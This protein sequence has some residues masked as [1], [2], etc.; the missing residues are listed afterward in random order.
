MTLLGVV[1]GARLLALE[2]AVFWVPALLIGF[3]AG[4]VIGRRSKVCPPCPPA[5]KP[6]VVTD[7][8]GAT[9]PDV[10]GM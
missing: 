3:G 7:A 1:D 6:R 2:S 4:I 9:Y 8:S 5:P 10:D